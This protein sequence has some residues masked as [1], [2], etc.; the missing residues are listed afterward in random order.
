VYPGVTPR[1]GVSQSTSPRAPQTLPISNHGVAIRDSINF[2]AGQE[3]QRNNG[4]SFGP[5]R[6]PY[7][8]LGMT[9]AAPIRFALSNHGRVRRLQNIGNRA[10]RRLTEQYFPKL[11][12]RAQGESVLQTNTANTAKRRKTHG[13]MIATVR[14][15]NL[16]ISESKDAQSHITQ[17]ISSRATSTASASSSPSVIEIVSSLPT[18]SKSRVSPRILNQPGKDQ[19]Y[20]SAKA[21]NPESDNRMLYVLE[22]QV[23]K[24]I[25]SAL[26]RFR[27]KLSKAERNAIGTRV[28]KYWLCVMLSCPNS[29]LDGAKNNK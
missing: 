14:G 23:F 2:G 13:E 15:Y 24:H 9:G 1:H 28:R 18:Q 26:H 4:L 3:L 20:S 22:N 7:R 16:N 17:S 8:S 11:T 12:I 29:L 5:E 19:A 10:N 27:K 25:T 21:T 6:G